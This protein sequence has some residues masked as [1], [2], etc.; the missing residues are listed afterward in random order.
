MLSAKGF[1]NINHIINNLQ[2]IDTICQKNSQF[3]QNIQKKVNNLK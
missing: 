1:K 3:S 2:H